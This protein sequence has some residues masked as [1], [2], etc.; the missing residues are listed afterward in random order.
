MT[1]MYINKMCD[2]LLSVSLLVLFLYVSFYIR[3]FLYQS[4][5]LPTHL[6]FFHSF[7]LSHGVI[8]WILTQPVYFLSF[9]LDK[10]INM[11]YKYCYELCCETLRNSL[12]SDILIKYHVF[13]FYNL[14]YIQTER[15][16]FQGSK[17]NGQNDCQ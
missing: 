7:F 3:L 12:L 16:V 4:T 9:K 17:K 10:L 11:R 8:V 5:Y 14:A 13:P 2:P 6:S 1:V 15:S